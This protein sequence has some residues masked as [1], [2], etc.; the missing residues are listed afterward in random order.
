MNKSPMMEHQS[1]MSSEVE[2][3]D[4]GDEDLMMNDA[5][6]NEQKTQQINPGE[7]CYAVMELIKFQSQ[8]M[9]ID[10]R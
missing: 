5:G 1:S 6:N 4:D 2:L 7:T 8:F 3:S 9:S 10:W